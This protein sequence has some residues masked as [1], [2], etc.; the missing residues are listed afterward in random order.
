MEKLKTIKGIGNWTARYIAMRAMEWPD[1]FLDT[2]IG[3]K[4]ALAPYITGNINDIA[5]PWRPW[6]SY[7]TINLWNSLKVSPPKERTRKSMQSYDYD[8]I[9]LKEI[10]EPE[11]DCPGIPVPLSD[12][13]LAERREAVLAKMDQNGLDVLVIYGDLEHGSNFEYLVGFLPRFEEALLVL[14]RNG[15]AYLMLGNENLNKA[16]KARLEAEAIH[17]PHFSLPNQPM[18]NTG[19]L[20][21]LLALAGVA[22]KRTG[23]VGWKNFTSTAEDNQKIFDLPAFII[24]AL[25]ELCGPENLTNETRLF[26]GRNGVRTINNPNEIAHYEFA[27][28]LASDCMMD[29]LR[30]MKP[31]VTEMEIGDRL[32]R[33]GQRNSIVTIA[34]FGPRFIKANMYPGTKQL[35]IGD[36]VSLSVGYKGGLSSRAGYA[37]RHAGQLPKGQEDYFEKVCAPYFTGIRA[38]VEQ[39]KVGMPG[40]DLYQLMDQ[41]LPKKEYNWGLCPGHL[42]ADEEW[43]SSPV[44]EGSVE[45]ISSGMLMQTDIIPSVP[46]YGGVSAESTV[47]IAGQELQERIHREYPL[48]Y[49]RMQKR[50]E[51]IHEHIGICLSEDVLPMCNTMAYMRPLM[52]GREAAVVKA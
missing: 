9:V 34:A 17:V 15:K 35:E 43:V 37:V 27:A 12:E 4:K 33:Y 24:M 6:R 36:T 31:G 48:M 1:S 22:G 52:L 29:A 18:G 42:T 20:K 5:D 39:I 7:A 21:D 11:N 3:V 50:R 14:H 13:T 30:T 26:I 28:S 40:G 47:C 8:A 2:D 44:Y 38:F 45:V 41:V 16:S 10:K 46:G 19:S 51:Y 23:V 49:A 25:T 32:V